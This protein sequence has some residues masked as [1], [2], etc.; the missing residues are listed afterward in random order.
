[1]HINMINE[2]QTRS[3]FVYG[4]KYNGFFI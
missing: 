2:T 4:Y 3:W 1:M